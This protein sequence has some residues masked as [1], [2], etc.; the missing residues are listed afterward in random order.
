MK[1][2]PN[3]Y[4]K[5]Y[6]TKYIILYPSFGY[7]IIYTGNKHVY[8]IAHKYNNEPLYK[9]DHKVKSGSIKEFQEYIKHLDKR[10]YIVEEIS[11]EDV[12]LEML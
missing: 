2:K 11:K 5:R 3:T 4:Y 10:K 9:Y 8:I 7:D 12:F 1:I 6:Y